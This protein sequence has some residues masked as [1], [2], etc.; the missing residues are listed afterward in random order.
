VDIN[1]NS[2][3]YVAGHKGMVGS[4]I[5]RKLENQG[6]TNLLT[7]SHEDLDLLDQDLVKSFFEEEIP[8]YVFV[9]AAKVGGINA[10]NILRADF[11]YQNI[12]IQSNL[13]HF[14]SQVNVK[15][16]LFMGS[17]CI[18]PRDCKQPMKEEYLLTDKLEYTNEPYAIAKIAG[19]KM[20][21]SYYHQYKNNF[22]SVMPTN[23]YGKNDNYNLSEG[24][25]FASL[26]RK[27]H[28]AKKGNADSVNLWGTGKPLREFIFVDDLADAAI[29][30]MNSDFKN[31]YD[32][33]LSHINLGTGHEISIKDLALLISKEIGYSG[34]IKFDD[35]MPDGTPRKLLDCTRINKLGWK[36]NTSLKNG[37][38]LTYKT[39]LE[40]N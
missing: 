19:I 37:I 24:H 26:I 6:Y 32:Q 13:I 8:E 30:I 1:L 18:Y 34:K 9:C 11:L 35:S 14:S 23:V 12:Q 16:L 22:F 39:F 38:S 15:K 4:A 28:E 27:F 21:E 3:I 29:F 10:N 40:E 7:R 17:S 25:V 31:F 20:C 36:H 33:G 5:L 2:K